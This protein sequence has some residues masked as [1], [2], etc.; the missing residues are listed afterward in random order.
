ML[1][2]LGGPMFGFLEPIRPAVRL[3]VAVVLAYVFFGCRSLLDNGALF[4]VRR[5]MSWSQFGTLV[6][7]AAMIVLIKTAQAALTDRPGYMAFSVYMMVIG[8]G[9][10]AKPAVFLVAHVVYF[11]PW[12]LLTA[13][14]WKPVCAQIHEYGL[15][16]TL[17]VLIGVMHGLDSESR[18]AI[19]LIP[20]LVPFFVMATESLAW[21]RGTYIAIAAMSSFASEV[22]LTIKGTFVDNAFLY[23]DQLYWMHHGPFISTETYVAHLAGAVVLGALLYI[24]CFQVQK[25]H[26]KQQGKSDWLFSEETATH[27]PWPKLAHD[28]APV[29]IAA[30]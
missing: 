1:G 3:S 27:H 28:E 25:G 10:V 26:G 23:P 19:Y 11:G 30:S 7:L 9:S 13:M 4:N 24:V 29:R 21:T 18:H 16:V 5:W 15:G 17:A 2:K 6:A 12:L 22:W 8:I 14:L 20:M